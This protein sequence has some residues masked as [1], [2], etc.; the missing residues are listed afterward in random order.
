LIDEA[1]DLGG[2]TNPIAP[3]FHIVRGD[4]SLLGPEPDI[5]SATASFERAHAMAEPFGA[6]MPQ[7]RAAVRLCRI[8]SATNRNVRLQTLRAIHASFTEGA[9]TPDLVEASELLG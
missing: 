8:A 9:S 3:L 6:R 7:L 5:T 4:L 1:I 2:P